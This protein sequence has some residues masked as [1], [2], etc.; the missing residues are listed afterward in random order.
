M[1]KISVK[2]IF[3]VEV[4]G[5][6]VIYHFKNTEIAVHGVLSKIEEELSADGFLRCNN[7]YLV[8]PR[9]IQSVEGYDIKMTNGDL[10]RISHP[11]KK[12]FMEELAA[13]LGK[14]NIV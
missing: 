2:S 8:N 7:C 12:K 1:Q 13:W 4:T 9:Y 14:G 3:Y 6:K 5:H 11:R 10:L